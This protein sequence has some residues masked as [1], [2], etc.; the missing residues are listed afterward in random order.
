MTR[1]MTSIDI[2]KKTR[3]SERN[4]IRIVRGESS[5]KGIS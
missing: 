1:M 5:K 3:M 4:A 2:E